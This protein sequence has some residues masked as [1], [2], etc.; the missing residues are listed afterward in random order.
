[1]QLPVLAFSIEE[2]EVPPVH[3]SMGKSYLLEEC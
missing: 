3:Y 2:K 1:M